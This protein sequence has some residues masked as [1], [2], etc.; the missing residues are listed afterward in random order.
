MVDSNG[1]DKWPGSAE[2]NETYHYY[3]DFSQIE[4]VRV[5]FLVVY[6]LII[7]CSIFGNGLVLLTMTRQKKLKQNSINFLTCN[8]A[9]KCDAQMWKHCKIYQRQ[10]VWILSLSHRRIQSIVIF[11]N[12]NTF[13]RNYGLV[14]TSFLCVWSL[15]RASGCS[16]RGKSFI[17]A[18]MD[19]LRLEKPWRDFSSDWARIVWASKRFG[20]Y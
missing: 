11:V 19:A 6:V 1:S 15:I 7:L 12:L 4:W 3:R 9:G 13:F 14:W 5:I 18:R 2:S 8:L 10:F 17:V 16:K 20:H